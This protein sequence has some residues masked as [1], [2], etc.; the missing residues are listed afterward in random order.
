[1]KRI[2]LYFLV[3]FFFFSC[4]LQAQISSDRKTMSEGVYEALVIEIPGLDKKTTGK[5]WTDY[6]KS[7]YSSRSKYN[8]KT[9]E[10]FTDD[11]D[12]AGIG[13]GNT[14]DIYA[15]IEEKA[16]GSQL[17]MWIDLGGAYLSRSEHGD[18]S[19]EA[20]KM[21]IRFGLEAA[22]EKIRLD[23]EDQ[24]KTLK[25]LGRDLEKLASYKERY[26]SDIEKAKQMI[27][28]A[29]KSIEENEALQKAK[30]EEI[31]NQEELI[32]MTKKKLNDL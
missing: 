22:K 3:L 24:E 5:L 25:D 10:Y 23:I 31:K 20:E 17:S 7:F 30:N 16:D 12:I 19:L 15:S 1:M 14:I 13:Q 11:A 27:A 26:E 28:D 18:R 9:K 4:S 29:E 2:S 21:L 32:E 6:T 8:R